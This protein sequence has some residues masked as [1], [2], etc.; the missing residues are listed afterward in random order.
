MTEGQ[1][2]AAINTRVSALQRELN[3]IRDRREKIRAELESLINA[4]RRDGPLPQGVQVRGPRVG[5]KRTRFRIL[6]RDGFAC[7]YCGRKAPDVELEVDHV[8]PTSKGG[9]SQD[10]NLVSAC[11]ECNGGKSDSLLSEVA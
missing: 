5:S 2:L 4:I 11:R 8:V 10:S 7:V 3:A 6:K 1:R 9:T